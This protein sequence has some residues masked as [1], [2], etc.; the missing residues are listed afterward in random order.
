M[1]LTFLWFPILFFILLLPGLTTIF[2]FSNSMLKP[3][4]LSLFTKKRKERKGKEKNRQEK[5]GEKIRSRLVPRKLWEIMPLALSLRSF[6]FAAS[7]S[8]VLSLSYSLPPSQGSSS[9]FFLFTFLIKLIT[10]KHAPSL[11]QMRVLCS[12]I[13]FINE[14]N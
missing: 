2:L 4:S 11:A 12:A 3:I 9:Q 5:N 10:K 1:F 8:L 14:E 13:G 6:G 7:L